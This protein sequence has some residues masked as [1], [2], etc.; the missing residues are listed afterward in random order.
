MRLADWLRE[1]G[2]EQYAAELAKH[3]VDLDVAPLLAEA[4]LE[5]LGLSLGHRKKFLHAA[6]QLS[7]AA[8]GQTAGQFQSADGGGAERRQLTVLFCDLADST[9]LAA[10]MDPEDLRH[11]IQD[12]QRLSTAALE[13][14]G[15]YVAKFMGD[16]ILAYFGYPTAHEDDAERAIRASFALLQALV[17]SAGRDLVKAR[18]GIATGLVVVGDLIG[19]GTAR[20]RNVIG[21]TPNLAARLQAIAAPNQIVIAPRT[22][23]L[24]GK[25]FNYAD[26]GE[27]ELKGFPVPIRVARVVSEGSTVRRSS[28]MV[29]P[30]H[31][32]VGRHEELSLLDK[33]WAQ[34]LLGEGQVVMLSGE[35][36][37]GKS[38]LTDA[39]LE[40]IAG[41]VAARID[42]Q[43]SAHLA[44]TAL[45]PFSAALQIEAGIHARDKSADQLATVF[46][47]H[48]QSC[49]VADPGA[50]QLLCALLALPAGALPAMSPQRQKM[51]TIAALGSLFCGMAAARPLVIVF[52]DL[53]WADP[54]TLE[55]L[56]SL[57]DSVAETRVMIILTSRPEFQPPW[58]NRSH[59]TTLTLNRL[60]RSES[61]A[62]IAMVAA[63]AE[64]ASDEI[65]ARIAERTDGIPLFIE[66][67]T[68]MFIETRQMQSATLTGLRVPATLRDSLMARLDRLGRARELAHVAAVI[69]RTFDQSLLQKLGEWEAEDIAENLSALESAGLLIHGADTQ[70]RFTHALL[71]DTAYES[72]LISQ[73]KELHAR[74]AE[75]YESSVAQGEM[76]QLEILAHHHARADNPGQA[77][78]YF[79]QAGEAAKARSAMREASNH[80]RRGLEILRLDHCRGGGD[81]AELRLLIAVGPVQQALEGLGAESVEATYRR[82]RELAQELGDKKRL[83]TVMWGQ[84]LLFNQRGQLKISYPLAH[85]LLALAT[86][87]DDPALKMQAY[88]ALWPVAFFHGHF[89]RVGDY[90]AAGTSLYAGL[91]DKSH[92]LVFGNHDPAP[93]ALTFLSLARWLQGEAAQ[94]GTDFSAA[95]ATA[96]QLGHPF[97]LGL[98]LGM[99]NWN[100]VFRRE[101]EKLLDAAE[102][103]ITL[104]AEQGFVQWQAYGEIQKGWA[105]AL[106]G[107]PETGLHM[108][109]R[110]LATNR[111][112]GG[113]VAEPFHLA[114]RAEILL[115]MQDIESALASL[116]EALE[117]AAANDEHWWTP[118]I[119]RLQ[120]VALQKSALAGR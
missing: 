109:D 103:L 114:L 113:H 4:D 16:G 48:L 11:L 34:A 95:V 50:R 43:C 28:A 29:K 53:H 102:Y 80:F 42:L 73:R 97:T 74:I 25:L 62:L 36:G 66:E 17:E 8:T 12:F 99:G 69:G 19:T 76:V 96:K 37:I 57:I 21:E 68:R 83:F 7:A 118:E 61:L 85:D 38:F 117:V 77:I 40:R 115:K 39:F 15:G 1:I 31:A 63:A 24:V 54:S 18:V 41:G 58:P 86:E 55:A 92:Q 120:S 13:R 49:G 22:R 2:L 81:G 65:A 30:G 75:I 71:Q 94:S 46:D 52:E 90:V 93:C 3:D 14:H 106:L 47:A 33:R 79:L 26:L 119:L 110:G 89:D 105:A 59:V 67:L 78:D 116:G 5:A 72:L 6:A 10:Q 88:H 20:E 27:H 51:L 91:A 87:I 100:Y 104:A 98:V 101:P 82:A 56:A 112:L 64:E 45:H 32:L 60:S 44:N 23:E 84:W 111:K 108:I 9:R 35:P 70:W 107:D